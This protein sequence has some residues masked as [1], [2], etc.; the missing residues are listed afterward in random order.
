MTPVDLIRERLESCFIFCSYAAPEIRHDLGIRHLSQVWTRLSSWYVWLEH[1]PG[2]F[3]LELRGGAEFETE[4]AACRGAMGVIRHFPPADQVGLLSSEEAALRQ[5]D[6]FDQTG[7]P[8][9]EALGEIGGSGLFVVGTFEMHALLA[10]DGLVYLFEATRPEGADN[11]G[12]QLFDRL[13][14]M[15]AYAAQLAPSGPFVW[16]PRG[17]AATICSLGQGEPFLR[18]YLAPEQVSA[19][20]VCDLTARAWSALAGRKPMAAEGSSCCCH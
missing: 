18:N 15:Q 8:R 20:S 3:M 9:W 13:V 10:G 11:P 17:R 16:G 1:T 7:T 14:G 5:S 12:A 4:G 19:P 2:A 6:A